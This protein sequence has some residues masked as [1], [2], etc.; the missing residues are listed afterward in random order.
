LLHRLVL[1]PKRTAGNFR[2]EK[3]GEKKQCLAYPT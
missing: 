1:G 2:Q 3:P